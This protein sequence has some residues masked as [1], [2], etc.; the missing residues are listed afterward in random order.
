MNCVQVLYRLSC[1]NVGRP[2][3]TAQDK[4]ALE[5][6]YHSVSK[7]HLAPAEDSLS[8]Q[9]PT[10]RQRRDYP[11]IYNQPIVVTNTSDH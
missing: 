7:I 11:R 5:A 1:H 4:P 10:D 8:A 2:P 6:S 9:R 3:Y